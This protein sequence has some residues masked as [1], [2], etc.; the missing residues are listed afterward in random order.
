MKELTELEVAKKLSNEFSWYNRILDI[1][2]NLNL[3]KIINYMGVI[4]RK[5]KEKELNY[6]LSYKLE[7]QLHNRKK[8]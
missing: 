3:Y 7:K 2:S 5:K 4:S 1:Y 6:K 8:K